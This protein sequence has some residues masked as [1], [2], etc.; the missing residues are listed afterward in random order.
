MDQR[1]RPAL[2]AACG[3]LVLSALLGFGAG[4]AGPATATDGCGADYRI[5]DVR[6]AYGYPSGA[7][8]RGHLESHRCLDFGLQEIRWSGWQESKT[9]GGSNLYV[10]HYLRVRAWSCGSL[11]A[12]DS[13][14][15]TS[16]WRTAILTGYSNHN[17][18]PPQGDAYGEFT[19]SGYWTWTWYR[20]V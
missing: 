14:T 13:A 16:A 12:N 9:S 1:Q 7:Q 18:C 11:Y 5:L 10:R 15:Q 17:V 6:D 20:N 8:L 4:M 2:V 19:R 3:L